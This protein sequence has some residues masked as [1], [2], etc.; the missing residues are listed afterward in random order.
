MPVI[1]VVSELGEVIEQAGPAIFVHVPVP[2]VAALAAI[3]APE[4]A[5]K[6]WFG[7]AL[8]FVTAIV[9][10]S[11]GLQVPVVKVHLKT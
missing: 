9:T 3:V 8:D 11:E 7:P 10:S 1:V 5:H 6:V 4:A 2:I